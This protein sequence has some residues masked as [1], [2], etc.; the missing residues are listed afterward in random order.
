M[1]NYGRETGTVSRT[2]VLLALLAGCATP[3]YGYTGEEW[4]ALTDEQR[5]AAKQ[6]YS[7]ILK[8]REDAKHDDLM[9]RSKQRIIRRG[10]G[11]SKN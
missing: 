7:Q 10:V 11:D 3:Y 8:A 6:N 9:E 2:V 5:E 1:T 4:A